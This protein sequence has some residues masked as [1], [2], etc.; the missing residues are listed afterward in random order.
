M[1]V[2]CYQLAHFCGYSTCISILEVDKQSAIDNNN[3]AEI[4]QA[5]YLL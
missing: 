3:K 2:K 1:F 5:Q 4:V